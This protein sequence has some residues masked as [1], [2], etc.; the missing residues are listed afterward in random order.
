LL[1][2]KQSQNLKK[3]KTK[4]G[5]I[6]FFTLFTFNIGK[7]QIVEKFDST[8]WVKNIT[9]AKA[10]SIEK[11]LP[12]MLVFSGS[13]WCK[14]CIKLKTQILLTDEF[15]TYA[16]THFVLLNLDF[17]RKAKN[18]LST[19]QQVHNDELAG[20]YN[21]EGT[22]PLVVVIDSEGK[23]LATS[24]YMDVTPAEYIKNLEA[25]LLKK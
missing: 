24:G 16:K 3:M 8:L 20:K 25:L 14:P 23:V 10:T 22:F 4:I 21:A 18:K 1:I 5:V 6:F 9:V 7:A 2:E 19:E 12:I 11:K 15:S 17:P 13:D